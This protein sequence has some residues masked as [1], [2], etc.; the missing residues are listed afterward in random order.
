MT[1]GPDPDARMPR[2]GTR[3]PQGVSNLARA[4]NFASGFEGLDETHTRR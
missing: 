3:L 1:A 4:R 2:V